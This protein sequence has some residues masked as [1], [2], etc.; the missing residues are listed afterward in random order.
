MGSHNWTQQC[1][2]CGFEKM[3]VSTYGN[4]H[5]EI[6][7]PICGYGSW[8]E[9]KVPDN[10]DIELAK[11]KLTEMDTKE[12]EEATELY[13]EDNTPLITRLKRKEDF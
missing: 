5:F 6:A 13:Y 2:Y 7:C 9:D 8:T 11:R 3:I 12:K 4:F 10:Y 1:P